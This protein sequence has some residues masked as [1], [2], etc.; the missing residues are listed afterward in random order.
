MQEAALRAEVEALRLQLLRG[1]S[2][3]E[4]RAHLDEFVAVRE[5]LSAGLDVQ[6]AE[7]DAL[8]ALVRYLVVAHCNMLQ[9]RLSHCVDK[10]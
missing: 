8:R 4:L 7:L 1:A 5:K 6:A 10:K 2:D 9:T 3:D